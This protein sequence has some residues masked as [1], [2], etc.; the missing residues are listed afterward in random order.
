MYQTCLPKKLFTQYTGNSEPQQ[1]CCII[2]I[3]I[4]SWEKHFPSVWPFSLVHFFQSRCTRFTI[5][6]LDVG[7][8]RWL[9]PISDMLILPKRLIFN[10][11]MPIWKA[12]TNV[13]SHFCCCEINM[14]PTLLWHLTRNISQ[15]HKLTLL[16]QNK[17]FGKVALFHF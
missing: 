8:S 13:R 2:I 7:Y 3:R 10:S 5:F 16:L 9:L 15:I 17:N 6:I 4:T 11:D 14:F 1:N 12:K